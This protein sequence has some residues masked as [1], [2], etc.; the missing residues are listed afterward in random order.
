M[1]CKKSNNL[2]LVNLLETHTKVLDG[3]AMAGRDSTRP[4]VVGLLSRGMPVLFETR[5]RVVSEISLQFASHSLEID[6]FEQNNGVGGL[7][8]ENDKLHGTTSGGHEFIHFFWHVSGCLAKKMANP[9]GCST[10]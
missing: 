8:Q 2:W 1:L 9:T 6:C 10:T 3:N 4:A 5:S 7:S